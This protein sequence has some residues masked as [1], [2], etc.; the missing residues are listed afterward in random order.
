MGDICEGPMY[1]K[2]GLAGALAAASYAEAMPICATSASEENSAVIAV[3]VFISVP[4][5]GLMWSYLNFE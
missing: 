1:Q 2:H 3:R 4:S 5:C